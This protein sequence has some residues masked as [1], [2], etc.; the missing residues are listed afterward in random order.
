MTVRFADESE[1]PEAATSSHDPHEV[2]E[3]TPLYVQSE[4]NLREVENAEKG[5]LH[6]PLVKSHPALGEHPRFLVTPVATTANELIMP[7][8]IISESSANRLTVK[9][10]V[11]VP[12]NETVFDGSSDPDGA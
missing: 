8:P 7:T 1:D 9:P 10:A 2:N 6:A 3:I 4:V 12:S 11:S 5:S